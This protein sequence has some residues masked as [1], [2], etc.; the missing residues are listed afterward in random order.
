[1]KYNKTVYSDQNTCSSNL[2]FDEYYNNDN[3]NKQV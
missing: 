3:N 2:T 1:M